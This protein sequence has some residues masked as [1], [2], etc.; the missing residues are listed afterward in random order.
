MRLIMEV[1]LPS[2]FSENSTM[3]TAGF[4][5]VIQILQNAPGVNVSRMM[6]VLGR[7]YDEKG[8]DRVDIDSARKAIE[9]MYMVAERDVYPRFFSKVE[10]VKVLL[11]IF[12]K[13]GVLPGFDESVE[14]M[15]RGFSN[16]ICSAKVNRRDHQVLK[17]FFRLANFNLMLDSRDTIRK[18]L[19]SGNEEI[20]SPGKA[21]CLKG[22]VGTFI[23]K[24]GSEREMQKVWNCVRIVFETQQHVEAIHAAL[25]Q[26][27]IAV[28]YVSNEELSILF[29]AIAPVLEKAKD[30]RNGGLCRALCALLTTLLMNKYFVYNIRT[31]LCLNSDYAVNLFSAKYGVLDDN[32]KL[33]IN[34]YKKFVITREKLQSILAKCDFDDSSLFAHSV[35]HAKLAVDS[36]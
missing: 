32:D 15:F 8:G 20:L 4:S 19:P 36:I 22:M 11:G 30:A 10:V 3:R 26:K 14:S 33:L 31:L 16:A 7:S 17:Y 23:W 9:I 24:L 35:A 34:L 2:I 12:S 6:S 25:A 28:N 13:H 29:T 21:L 1:N 27:L 5:I 18:Y